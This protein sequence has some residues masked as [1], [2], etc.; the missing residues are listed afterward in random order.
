M[1][2]ASV[3]Q[4]VA[5]FLTQPPLPGLMA[6]HRAM[7]TIIPGTDYGAGGGWAF[8]AIGLVHIARSYDT[9]KAGGT[10]GHLERAVNYTVDFIM[11]AAQTN[12]DAVTGT[13]NWDALIE[14]TKVRLR[15]NPS[16]GT[17]GNPEP[18]LFAAVGNGIPGSNAQDIIV[19]TDLPRQNKGS[20]YFW[21][22]IQFSVSEVYVG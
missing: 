22:K 20:I 16:L 7:P 10:P 19:D 17:A 6:V 2:M 12:G 1:S 21:T 14:A 3:R 15:S 8:G 4:G 18:I 13:D 11:S 5:S 9:V